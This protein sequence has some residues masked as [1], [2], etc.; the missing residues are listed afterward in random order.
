MTDLS[1]Y[2]GIVLNNKCSLAHAFSY[3]IAGN[4]CGANIRGHWSTNILPT[5]EA[6]LP[7]F[8]CSASSNHENKSTNWLDIAEPRIITR[9]IRYNIL[10]MDTDKT[11]LLVS[12]VLQCVVDVHISHV[13]PCGGWLTPLEVCSDCRIIAVVSPPE[14]LMQGVAYMYWGGTIRGGIE[15]I[16]FSGGGENV[17]K[18]N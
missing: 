14:S 9:Y 4:F 18:Y 7:T 6:T 12:V 17:L 1:K 8:T 2:T 10:P 15:C 5:N 16:R 3:R 13:G 11:H